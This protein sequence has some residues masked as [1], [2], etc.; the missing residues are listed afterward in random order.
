[1]AELE[2]RA[3]SRA[4]PS[5]LRPWGAALDVWR[6]A[7]AAPRWT[8]APELAPEPAEPE[9]PVP[10]STRRGGRRRNNRKKEEGEAA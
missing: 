6:V 2:P 10:A 7:R 1:V 8:R 5:R 4:R 9:P 3:P